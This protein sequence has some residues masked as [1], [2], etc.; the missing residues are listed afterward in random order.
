MCVQS[1]TQPATVEPRRTLFANVFEA[2]MSL[3]ALSLSTFFAVSSRFRRHFILFNLCVLAPLF[4][5]VTMCLAGWV[6]VFVAI[7]HVFL[8]KDER[9]LTPPR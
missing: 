5:I 1:P 9:R 3:W 7:G 6:A 2:E 8:A 4:T